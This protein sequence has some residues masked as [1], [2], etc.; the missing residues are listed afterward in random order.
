MGDVEGSDETHKYFIKL[1]VR[2]RPLK[3]FTAERMEAILGRKGGLVAEEVVA[4][5]G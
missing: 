1:F 2:E 3:K 5:D 4:E